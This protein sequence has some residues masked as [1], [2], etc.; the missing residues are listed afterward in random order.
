MNLLSS[1]LNFF[2][3][4]PSASTEAAAIWL[5]GYKALEAGKEHCAAKRDQ[6]ALDCFDTAI[7]CG[8]KDGEVFAARG[9]CLQALEWHFDAIDDF[10]NA[11]SLEPHDCNHYFQRAMSKQSVGDKDGFLAD[12]QEAI[13]RSKID[14]Q[15]T[16]H[17]NRE[18]KEMGWESAAA[19]YEVQLLVWM[20]DFVRVDRIKRAELRGRRNDANS[21]QIEVGER[22]KTKA[23]AKE[24]SHEECDSPQAPPP[25]TGLPGRLAPFQRTMLQQM[26]CRPAL[27]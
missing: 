7:E 16:R 22:N 17:H 6:Q 3:K 5:R 11:I 10:S 1:L 21:S 9:G 18:A 15:L 4:K 23:G 2:R 25:Q 13:R 19:I 27:L 8:F 26:N 12:A 14:N 24:T 20:P